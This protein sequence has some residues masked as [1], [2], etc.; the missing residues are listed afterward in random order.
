MTPTKQQFLALD[1]GERRIGVAIADSIGRIATPLT[2]VQ[3]DGTEIVQ[4]QRLLLEHAITAFVIGLPRNQ[5]G[6]ETAQSNLIRQFVQLRLGGFAL[7][8]A[9]QDESVTSV[10]AEERLSKRKKGYSK[11]DIDAE[12][13]AII[14]QDYLEATNG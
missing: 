2:T 1:I 8:I 12:A 5:Q 11:A 9:F 6:E 7:P 13:A 3:V 14:L 10:I 4:I